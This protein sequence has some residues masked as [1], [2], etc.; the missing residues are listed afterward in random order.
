LTDKLYTTRVYTNI[1]S[2]NCQVQKFGKD[3]LTFTGISEDVGTFAPIAF[4][5]FTRKDPVFFI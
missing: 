2:G 5:V 1:V 3:I 4:P